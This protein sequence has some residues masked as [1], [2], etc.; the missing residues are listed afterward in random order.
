MAKD[1]KPT[2]RYGEEASGNSQHDQP[3][4]QK[5]QWILGAIVG[6]EPQRCPAKTYG[7]CGQAKP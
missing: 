5:G 3:E 6:C 4:S 7:K 2:P 1:G